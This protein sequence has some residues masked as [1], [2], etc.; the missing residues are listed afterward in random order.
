MDKKVGFG[1]H[2]NLTFEQLINEQPGYVDWLLKQTF[3]EERNPELYHFLKNNGAGRKAKCDVDHNTLQAYFLDDKNLQKILPKKAIIYDIY[4][5]SDCNADIE[6]WYTFPPSSIMEKIFGV[7]IYFLLIEIKPVVGEDYPEV[8]RQMRRH[9][10]SF[11]YQN[12]YRMKNTAQMLIYSDYTG[13][14][15]LPELQ[16]FFGRIKVKKVCW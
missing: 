4:F 1:K 6:V 7:E 3:L 15:S 16:K 12:D 5:E 2:F 11:T 13:R 8:L 9:H 10:R 14:L